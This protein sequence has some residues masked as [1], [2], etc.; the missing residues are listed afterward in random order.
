MTKAYSLLAFF[1]LANVTYAQDNSYLPEAKLAPE[2]AKA[3]NVGAGFTQEMIHVNAEWVNPYGIA[4]AKAGVFIDDD[5]TPGGQ[6]GF[7]YPYHLTGKDK[8]GYYVGVYAGHIDSKSVDNEL[9]AQLGAGVDLAYVLLSKERIS[10]F[11]I[12]IG[13]GEELEDRNGKVVAE[14]EPRI[15]FSYTLSIGL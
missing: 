11:S 7:R 13:A 14:T 10:S 4:Y 8:N 3:W 9:K 2:S 12:G 6:V 1:A 5:Y 15:Q